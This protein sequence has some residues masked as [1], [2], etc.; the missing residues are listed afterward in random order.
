MTQ[1]QT[2]M[3]ECLVVL[4]RSIQVLHE[5]PKARAIEI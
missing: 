3:Q 2:S 4:A 5:P 1:A